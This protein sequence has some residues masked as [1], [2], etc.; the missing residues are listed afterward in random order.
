MLPLEESEYKGLCLL[1]DTFRSTSCGA[2][3]G[4]PNIVD[5]VRFSFKLQPSMLFDGNGKFY[6]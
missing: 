2:V 1:D 6:F 5:L 3:Y 4:K